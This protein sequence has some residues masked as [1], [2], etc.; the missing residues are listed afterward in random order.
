[1]NGGGLVGKTDSGLYSLFAQDTRLL[2][3]NYKSRAAEVV[4]EVQ[5]EVAAPRSIA[6]FEG[7][8]EAEVVGA[9]AFVSHRCKA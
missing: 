3:T 2:A 4:A 1:M 6:E 5:V 8:F 9:A 7:G